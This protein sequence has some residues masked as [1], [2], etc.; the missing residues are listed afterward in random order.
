MKSLKTNIFFKIGMIFLLILILLVPTALV[1]GLIDER[2]YRQIEAINEVSDKWSGRQTLTGP[3]IS[4]PYDSYVTHNVIQG[5]SVVAKTEKEL[6]HI[7]LLPDNLNI[8]GSI[9]PEKR[10]RG[11]FEVVVYESMLNISGDFAGFDFNDV[12]I[13]KD[14]IHFDKAAINLG[15]SDLKG[16]EDQITMNWNGK[17]RSFDS[18]VTNTNLVSSGINLQLDLSQDISKRNS[19]NAD[20]RLKGSHKLYFTPV[21]KTTDVHLASTWPTP[22]FS[23]KFLPD[24]REIKPDGFKAHWNVLH[25]NRNYPQYW[26]GYDYDTRDSVFGTD[27]LL[28]VDSYKKSDR[29][30]KYAIL[31]IVLTFLVFFFV[32][33][34]GNVFIHP[35]Q[36][37][38][39]GLALIVFYSLLLSISEHLMFNLAY[40][41]ATVL[42]ITLVSLYATAILKSKRLAWMIFGILL[43]MYAFIFTII[44]LENY[45]LLLGSIGIFAV[46]SVVM[47]YSKNIDWYNIQLKEK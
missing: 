19:F 3:F 10:Y 29:V 42:T 2:E 37:L 33:I 8:T 15:I 32:E 41:I 47:Y 24:D 7:H 25:L 46:L 9:H 43:I 11:I 23:G 12:N 4:I 26:T 20:I 36:Y 44:Q 35:I 22:S 28:P 21:G 13:E 38:L 30:A 31:F 5:D 6:R 17:T 18:G 40:G 14:N 39:V 16:I 27:L 45:A 1:T 34:L